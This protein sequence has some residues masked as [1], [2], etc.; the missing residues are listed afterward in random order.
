[1]PFIVSRRDATGKYFEKTKQTTTKEDEM[2]K[3]R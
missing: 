3:T 1:M 2:R